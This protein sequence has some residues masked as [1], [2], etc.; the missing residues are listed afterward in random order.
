M[1][2]MDEFYHSEEFYEHLN[3]PNPKKKECKELKD[4]HPI[5]LLSSVYKMIARILASRLKVVMIGIIS[6]PQGAF[7]EGRQIFY[8][9]LI[10]NECIEDWRSSGKNDVI[11]KLDLEKAYDHID[12][13][14]LDYI[15]LRMGFRVK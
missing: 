8:G 6:P 15:L 14:F 1:R 10:A 13:G 9:V 5:S 7:I 12:W 3:C 2:I 4:Y 11:C